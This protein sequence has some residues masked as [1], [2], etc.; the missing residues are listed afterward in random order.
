MLFV[1]GP[2]CHAPLR[3]EVLGEV[4]AEPAQLAGHGLCTRPKGGWPGL[5]AGAGVEGL[6][7]R[8]LS[9]AQR[10]RADFFVTGFGFARSPV[11]VTLADG[12]RVKA[13][14]Y[15]GPET[16][17]AAWSLADWA[18]RWGPIWAE[19]AREAMAGFG[20]ISPDVLARRWPMIELRAASRLRAAVPHPSGVRSAMSVAGDVEVLDTR[21]PY[22][23]Y[24]ALEELDL[25]FRRFDGSLSAPVT[26]AGFVGGDAATVLPWDPVTD[27][28]LLVEQF[29]VGPMLRGDPQPWSLE[30]IAGRVD[31]GEGPET[32][33]RRE[34]EEEAGLTLGALHH[35]ADYY[36]SPGAVTEYVFSYVAEADLSGRGGEIG[37]EAAEHEDIRSH[38]IA[39]DRLMALIASGE[40]ANGPLI[41]SALWL[42]RHRAG[43]G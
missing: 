24:F 11:E 5:T 10:A 8:G 30:P 37:G 19:A 6:L 34:A 1:F 3:A 16:E 18:G 35:V 13:E 2:L 22:T 42:Q 26:R 7:L 15:L 36:P 39:F 21:R 14:A 43:R 28:V 38:V 17:G 4:T 12:S 41:L 32:T 23:E 9:Y 27:R 33:V 20:L 31:P 29:R 25:R 40:V